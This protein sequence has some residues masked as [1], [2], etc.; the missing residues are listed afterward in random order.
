MSAPRI[1]LVSL[2]L[3]CQNWWKFWRSSDKNNFARYFLRHGVSPPDTGRERKMSH[4]VWK[5]EQN[6]VVLIWASLIKVKPIMTL[7][8]FRSTI[9]YETHTYTQQK[10]Y[11]N[12]TK[13]LWVTETKSYTLMALSSEQ[14]VENTA[15]LGSVMCVCDV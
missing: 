2:P 6:V 7:K 15:T 10:S 1:I 14:L 5:R 13:C 11:Q 3:F 4:E 12:I 8:V 9:E